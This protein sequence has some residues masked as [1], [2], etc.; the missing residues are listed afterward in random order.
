MSRTSLLRR[1]IL[2]YRLLLVLGANGLMTSVIYFFLTV[3]R[4]FNPYQA[5]FLIGLGALAKAISEVPTGIIADKFSRKYSILIGYVVILISWI[6]ILAVTGFIPMFLFVVLGG[7]GGSFISGADDALLYDT[8]KELDKTDQFKPIT[9]ISE[10]IELVA[11]AATV[12]IGGLLGSINFLL[13]LVAHITLLIISVFITYLLVEPQMTVKGEKIEQIG[14]ILHAKKSIKT[15]VSETGLRSGLLGSFISLALILA[16]F[17]STKNILSPVLDQYGFA[18]STIGLITSAIILIK[19]VGA[20]IASKVSKQ[21]N[22][23]KEVVLCLAL[24]ILGLLAITLIRIPL[25]QLTIFVFIISLDNVI[26]VNLKAIVNEKIESTQRS[27]VLSLLSLLARSTEML[28]LTSFG[29][30]VGA[31]PIGLALLFTTGWLVIAAVILALFTSS[32]IYVL[33]ASKASK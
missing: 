7:I 17:K 11:F 16:V 32:R 30:I 14:Y 2:L 9:N 23:K 21:G 25:L 19:A 20:F 10:S 27:T 1:N 6:G 4:G 8:L 18:V 13:P 12:L 3:T 5:L 22:E 24:C 26:L 29:W 31:Y 15:I 28:F 33:L